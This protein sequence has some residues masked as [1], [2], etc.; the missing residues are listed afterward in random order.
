MCRRRTRIFAVSCLVSVGRGAVSR[1]DVVKSH[2]QKLFCWRAR[3]FSMVDEATI[4]A[5][6]MTSS[7]D[8]T[9]LART[10]T[11]MSWSDSSG[12]GHLEQREDRMHERVP[13]CVSR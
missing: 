3:Y 4:S 10:C 12:V 1:I 7:A 5:S 13:F 9:N 8:Y 2:L 11:R 6:W